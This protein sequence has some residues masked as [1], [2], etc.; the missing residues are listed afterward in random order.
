MKSILQGQQLEIL[1]DCFTKANTRIEHEALLVD[2][3]GI[4]SLKL[5]PEKVMNQ[6]N[7][8]ALHGAD[9]HGLRLAMHVHQANAAFVG[10]YHGQGISLLQGPDVIDDVHTHVQSASHGDGMIGVD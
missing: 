2:A 8:I 5:R 4:C 10:G 9:L 1:L 3:S 7:Y 6:M